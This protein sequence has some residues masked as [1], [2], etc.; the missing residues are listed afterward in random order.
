MSNLGRIFETKPQSS[1]PSDSNLPTS[2]G[3]GSMARLK[4][5]WAGEG[6]LSVADTSTAVAINVRRIF[7]VFLILMIVLVGSNLVSLM[8]SYWISDT[9]GD[10]QSRV[11]TMRVVIGAWTVFATL[12]VIVGIVYIVKVKR[13]TRL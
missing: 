7:L 2:S 5:L 13:V 1:S 3:E 11:D 8:V 4:G 10:F 12:I 9:F 6:A